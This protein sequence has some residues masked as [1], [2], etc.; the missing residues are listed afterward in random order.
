MKRLVKIAALYVAKNMFRYAVLIWIAV[1]NSE[2]HTSWNMKG[3]MY[4]NIDEI[5]KY[6]AHRRAGH[7][8]KLS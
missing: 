2:D 6:A 8:V 5:L 3:I 7:K 1:C 4:K